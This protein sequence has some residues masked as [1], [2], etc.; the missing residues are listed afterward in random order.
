M[1]RGCS[2][3]SG[4]GYYS[5][6]ASMPAPDL[7]NLCSC[8]AA[9]LEDELIQLR[10]ST[11]QALKTSW[12]E[13]ENL[14]SENSR[15]KDTIKIIDAELSKAKRELA[16]SK[17]REKDTNM[18]NEKLMQKLKSTKGSP[19]YKTIFTRGPSSDEVRKLPKQS[20]LGPVPTIDESSHCSISSDLD[21]IS[22]L[23]TRTRRLGGGLTLK[24]SCSTPACSRPA[25]ASRGIRRNDSFPIVPGNDS[26]PR[27][28]SFSLLKTLSVSGNSRL[29]KAHNNFV[30]SSSLCGGDLTLKKSCS[31]P[32][33]ST[34]ARASRGI[35]KNDSFPRNDSFSLL[36]R[37]SGSGNSKDEDSTIV[38][39]F[40]GGVVLHEK[41]STYGGPVVSSTSRSA[42][43]RGKSQNIMVSRHQLVYPKEHHRRGQKD[44]RKSEQILASRHQLRRPNS[45]VKMTKT[46]SS[47][48][49]LVRKTQN[50]SMR[51]SYGST[52]QTLKNLR[53]SS[54]SFTSASSTKSSSSGSILV[55]KTQNESMR[56]SYGSTGQILKN[57]KNSSR[58]F[59]SASSSTK[60]NVSFDKVSIREYPRCVGDNPSVTTG[61]PMS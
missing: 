37:V 18:K 13:V 47:G 1:K 38:D 12:D 16:E 23:G 21:P 10:E 27:N 48:S 3:G 53:N 51:S 19:L 49:N 9:R 40:T 43:G 60:R 17:S 55:Q 2:I 28:D 57:L 35:P 44:G 11:K 22:L 5:R 36:K 50:E 15:L 8:D 25:L 4:I 52:G 41:S 20:Q 59:T 32:A 24:K 56:S 14:H 26:S 61:P 46:T 45:E 34:P 42:G 58:S 54:R 30:N 39:R 7:R 29:K 6:P 31:T 33:C